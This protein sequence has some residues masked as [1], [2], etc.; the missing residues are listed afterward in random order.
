MLTIRHSTMNR[1]DAC[2]TF[3][4]KFRKIA[5]KGFFDKHE[6]FDSLEEFRSWCINHTG[7]NNIDVSWA[8]QVLLTSPMREELY[9][10]LEIIRNRFH[11]SPDNSPQAWTNYQLEVL[12]TKVEALWTASI[13]GEYI[14]Q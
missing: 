12:N 9:D 6:S 5:T 10:R 2:A 3:R 7:L 11:L 1:K 14:T 8:T 4:A 13:T